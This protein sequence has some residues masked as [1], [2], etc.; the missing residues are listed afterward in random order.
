MA[1]ILAYQIFYYGPRMREAEELRRAREAAEMVAEQ[2][3]QAQEAADSTLAAARDDARL[4]AGHA[5]DG[6]VPGEDA[7]DDATP[8]GLADGGLPRARAASAA[9]IVVETPLYEIALS[10]TGAEIRTMRL[11]EFE[12]HGEPV[13]ILRRADSE[14]MGETDLVVPLSE[15]RGAANVILH[16]ETESVDLSTVRFDAYL[17]GGVEPLL[18]GTT[19]KLDNATPERSIMLRAEGPDG[20]FIEKK[21]VFTHDTYVVRA[22]VRFS[23]TH[24]PF[25]RQVEWGLGEGMQPTEVKHDD[26]YHALRAHLRLGDEYHTKKRGDFD[27]YYRGTVHWAAVQI[28]YFTAI[29]M[30]GEPAAGGASAAGQ[31]AANA[32]TA[33]IMLPAPDRR[34]TVD[35][36]VEYYLGPIDYGVLKDFNRGLERNVDMGIAIFRPVSRIVLW[37]LV[38]L[39]KF[40]PNYGLVIIILSVFTKVLFYR[41]THKSFKSMRDMQAL[42]P[43]LQ[44]IKEKYKD[45]RQKISQETMRVYKEAGVNPLGGCLPMLLQMPVFIAL[46]NVL[47]NTIELRRA[48]FLGWIDDLSQQDVLATLPFELPFMGDAVSVLPLLMGVGMLL[49]SKIGGGIAGPS[50]SATQPKM[51]MYMMPILFTVLFYRMPSGLVLYWIVNTVLSVAQQYYINKGADKDDAAKAALEQKNNKRTKTAKSKTKPKAKGR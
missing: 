38:W 35:Q 21:F 36:T 40:I 9:T 18:D 50:S 51:M 28:K 32:I 24:F 19:I 30:A 47:R 4:E 13:Q 22:G 44:A 16:G 12:T 27:E 33:S 1:L 46:F 6:E 8:Y 43:K 48:P 31:K 2:E 39:H 25:V 41:L 5:G 3:R 23:A 14:G 20:R 7:A 42:Q 29:V 11:L 45:D 17:D 37:S 10:T 49:Q 26:D 15:D 34:G